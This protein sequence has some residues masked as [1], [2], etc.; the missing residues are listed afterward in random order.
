MNKLASAVGI[1]TLALTTL[2]ASPAMASEIGLEG[3]GADARIC[4]ITALTPI[5]VGS[6]VAFG[7]TWDGCVSP[8]AVQLVWDVFGPN[9]VMAQVPQ[10]DSGQYY[11]YDCRWGS[12][13]SRVM[14]SRAID[15]SGNTDTS[16]GVTFNSGSNNCLL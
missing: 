6:Q 16:T 12:P 10:A 9:Q 2:I 8:V 3:S 4:N 1:V 5:N 15:A 13:Q 14:Y 7:G 11:G